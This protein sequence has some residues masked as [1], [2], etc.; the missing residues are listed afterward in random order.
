MNNGFK[1]QVQTKKYPE[2]G[3]GRD[4]CHGGTT[5]TIFTAVRHRNKKKCA[6]QVQFYQI[7]EVWS[8]R[9]LLPKSSFSG[10]P[11]FGR[12]MP[13]SLKTTKWHFKNI[14]FCLD[15]VPYWE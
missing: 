4:I 14:T 1:F 7:S 13:K 2:L 11:Q 8:A 3:K 5:T 9:F 15:I 6:E 12:K 10:S